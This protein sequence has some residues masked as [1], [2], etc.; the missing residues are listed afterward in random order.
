MS[1][2]DETVRNLAVN[3]CILRQI[4]R[5]LDEASYE[6]AMLAMTFNAGPDAVLAAIQ[7]RHGAGI[8]R[9]GVTEILQEKSKE[10][11]ADLESAYADLTNI[12]EAMRG[13]GWTPP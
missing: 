2:D 9:E 10:M 1:N 7:A 8:T 13:G 5:T 12:V 3:A 4:A 6:V 11:L